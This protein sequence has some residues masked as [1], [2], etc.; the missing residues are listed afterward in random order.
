MASDEELARHV[1]QV[2]GCRGH[3]GASAV[4]ELDEYREAAGEIHNELARRIERVDEEAADE[5]DLA[6]VVER[7]ER[8]ESRLDD[9][10]SRL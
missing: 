6:S 7:L 3:G 8:L 10:E 1:S 9:L 2:E 5:A 4:E